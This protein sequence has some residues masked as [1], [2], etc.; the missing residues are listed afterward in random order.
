MHLAQRL[1]FR[2]SVALAAL[3]LLVFFVM[4]WAPLGQRTLLV[5]HWMVI[6]TYLAPILLL[7]SAFNINANGA[8]RT[9]AL[10]ILVAYIAHQF[11]EHWVDALGNSYSFYAHVNALLH[12]M[13]E[14]DDPNLMPLTKSA[15]FFINTSLVWLV[16][17]QAV[18]FGPK[19]PFTVHSIMSIAL[20][21]AISHVALA[22]I[23]HSYNPGLVTSI[24]LFIPLALAYT[25]YVVRSQPWEMRAVWVSIGWAVIAHV[26]MVWGLI[27]ANVS[28]LFSE[29][30]Y[31][32]LL[33]AW[34]LVPAILTVRFRREFTPLSARAGES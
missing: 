29:S 12:S 19:Q 15:I 20:V 22:A 7:V 27:A 34:S 3:T 24:F 6:G 21:N 13:L 25:A 8:R 26:L 17:L 32:V 30:V 10:V 33:I 18:V 28:G 9:W 11:E 4:L 1:Q 23:T 14:I 16:G 5:E 31:V 2:D